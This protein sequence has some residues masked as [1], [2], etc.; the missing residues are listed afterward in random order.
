MGEN[1]YAVE[2]EAHDRITEARAAARSRTLIRE[3]TPQHRGPYALG[4]GLIRL[5]SWLLSRHRELP[6]ELS[7][8]L[9]NMREAT[10]RGRPADIL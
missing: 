5:G 1:W 4:I 3:L 10:N 9:A 6:T 8:A 2:Q 7:R